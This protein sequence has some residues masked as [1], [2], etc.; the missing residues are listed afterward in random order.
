MDWELIQQKNACA[1]SDAIPVFRDALKFARMRL[2]PG[3]VGSD[4]RQGVS[5]LSGM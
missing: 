4:R 1:N 5:E 2:I 3:D